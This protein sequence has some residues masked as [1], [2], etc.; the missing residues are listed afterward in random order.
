MNALRV[1]IVGAVLAAAALAAFLPGGLQAQQTV[2]V[3]L[4]EQNNSGMTGRAMLT[5]EGAGTKVV[6]E[7]QNAPG[8]HPVHI[9]AGTCANLNPAPAFP[10]TAINGNRSE[11]TVNATIQQILAA[12][13]AINAHKSPQEA[14][15]Y[16]AC[17]NITAAAAAAPAAQPSPPAAAP[18][19]A[20][21]PAP[22]AQPTPAPKPAAA[23]AQ[24]PKPAA[25]PPAALP[26]TG[27]AEGASPNV[28]VAIVFGLA[29]VGAGAF[30]I[31]R[32]RSVP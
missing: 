21:P 19:P 29:L 4:A 9:H 27:E 14:S 3:T 23:P 2:T 1:P 31:R 30:A 26:R 7:M 11:T 6:L 13:H 10:L 28:L 25:S 5:P 15:V 12:P 24:A 22:A 18:K 16:T 17:G 8:P 20:A 32:R